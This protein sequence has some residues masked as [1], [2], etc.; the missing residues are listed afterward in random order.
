MWSVPSNAPG[1]ADWNLLAIQLAA[2]G[3]SLEGA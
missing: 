3:S 2:C 1:M